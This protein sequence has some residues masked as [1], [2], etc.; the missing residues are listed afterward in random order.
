LGCYGRVGVE[1]L[2]EFEEVVRLQAGI[3]EWLL[4]AARLARS[5]AS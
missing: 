2:G 3:R 1:G 4:R 5:A